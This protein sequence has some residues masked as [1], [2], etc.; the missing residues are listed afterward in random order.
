MPEY[1]S[2]SSILRDF[3]NYSFGISKYMNNSIKV[4][5]VYNNTKF[6]N[7]EIKY[8]SILVNLNTILITQ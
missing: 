2:E 4:Q 1:L 3:E 6:E 5:A 8:A 7:D